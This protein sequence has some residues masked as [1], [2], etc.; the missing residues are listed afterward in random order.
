MHPTTAV[1]PVRQDLLECTARGGIAE[2]LLSEGRGPQRAGLVWW[3]VPRGFKVDLRRLPGLE[4]LLPVFHTGPRIRARFRFGMRRRLWGPC[5][6]GR[7]PSELHRW[8]RRTWP[9]AR[10]P[11][12]RWTLCASTGRL[13]TKS[14]ARLPAPWEGGGR[15]A[16]LAKL[17]GAQEVEGRKVERLPLAA[18]GH[19]LADRSFNPLLGIII[20]YI[21]ILP[22]YLKVCKMSAL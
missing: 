4:E 13:C 8:N 10:M 20:A 1:T 12:T 7:E 3:D 9:Q 15:L 6:N 22:A 2:Q 19:P 11:R 21:I 5:V 18:F 17:S 14:P 16:V